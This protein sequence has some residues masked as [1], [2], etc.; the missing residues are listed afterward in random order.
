MP[1]RLE[2]Q[3][4]RLYDSRILVSAFLSSSLVF[5]PFISITFRSMT[6]QPAGHSKKK[7]KEDTHRIVT[8]LEDLLRANRGERFI[9]SEGLSKQKG[10]HN[11]NRALYMLDTVVM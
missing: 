11:V 6:A 10:V 8:S 1:W 2:G 4:D 5:L 3:G 7:K 9:V